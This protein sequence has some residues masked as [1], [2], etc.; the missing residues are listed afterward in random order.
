MERVDAM[1]PSVFDLELADLAEDM[2][3]RQRRAA[4]DETPLSDQEYAALVEK[5][6]QRAREEFG[7]LVTS[8]SPTA[9]G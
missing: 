9:W 6:M 3:L 4:G 8:L 2:I 5:E 1:R 7:H